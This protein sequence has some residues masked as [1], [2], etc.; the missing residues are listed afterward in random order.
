M[1]NGWEIPQPGAMLK[2]DHS[3]PQPHQ[4]TWSQPMPL[5]DT[6]DPPLPSQSCLHTPH[7]VVCWIPLHRIAAFSAHARMEP[8]QGRNPWFCGTQVWW[9]LTHH[10]KVRNISRES[11]PPHAVSHCLSHPLTKLSGARSEQGVAQHSGEQGHQPC[12]SLCSHPYAHT[13]Q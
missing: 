11:H 10:E 12:W 5:W 1:A 3:S 9:L 8:S 6:R 7:R 2:D 4:N 13:P